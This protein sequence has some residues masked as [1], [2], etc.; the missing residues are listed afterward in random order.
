MA[1]A[2]GGNGGT[3]SPEVRRRVLLLG[4][5]AAAAVVTGRAFQLGVLEGAEW[6]EDALAQ[7]GDTIQL[8][9]PRGTIYDRDGLPLAATSEAIS[10]QVAPREVEDRARVATLLREHLGMSAREVS[11]VLDT[12]RRWVV[13]PGRYGVQVRERLQNV[14]G[15]HFETVLQRFYPNGAVARELLGPVRL[16]GDALGGLE[17]EFDSVLSGRPGRAVARQDARGRKLPGALLRAVEPVPGKDVFLSIDYDLQEIA[18]EALNEALET[19]G[20]VSGELLMTDPATGE[21]LAAVSRLRDG[22]ARN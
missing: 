19:T 14:A 4:I 11:S 5:L 6:R 13:L 9:A 18:E 20:A 1:N 10:V 15:V 16:D 21:V 8:P 22:R 3:R 2:R 17:L 7:Q 12:E